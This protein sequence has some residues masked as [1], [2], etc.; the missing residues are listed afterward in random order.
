M[1]K[2]VLIKTTDEVPA[3][4]AEATRLRTLKKY[5]EADFVPFGVTVRYDAYLTGAGKVWS[6][7]DVRPT[8][9]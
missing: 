5:V 4:V 3:L 9:G 2:H 8:D 1:S 6:K 7:Y